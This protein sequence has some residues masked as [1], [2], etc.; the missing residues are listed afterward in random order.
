ME[1]DEEFF[2][3]REY[4]EDANGRKTIAVPQKSNSEVHFKNKKYTEFSHISIV[5]QIIL[6]F[7][8]SSWIIKFN[9]EGTHVAIAGNQGTII[10]YSIGSKEILQNPTYLNEHT[11][12]ITNLSWSNHQTL[13]SSSID[14][15]VKEWGLNGPS[16]STFTYH[17]KVI[18]CCYL[19]QDNNFFVAAFED[20]VIRNVYIPTG[21]IINSVQ[22]FENIYC[23]ALSPSGNTAAVGMDKGKVIPFRIRETDFKLIDRPI[24]KAKN[25]RGFKKKGKK[26]SGLYFVNDN[27]L[28]VT[29]LDSNIRLFS[30]EDYQ[31][32][33]KYKGAVLKTRDFCGTATYDKEYVICGSESGKFLIWRYQLPGEV[34]N[35]K[36]ESVKGG[37]AK[38]AEYVSVAP[39]SA[40][41][42]LNRSKGQSAYNYLIVTIDIG[43][44][45]KIYLC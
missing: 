36:Y 3:A 16:I 23:L 33:Q 8:S 32:K 45:L 6:P 13:L 15:T 42:I 21:Q 41:E 17:C 18:S 5:S 20:F 34:K 24:L 2:D 11:Y 38:T 14:H 43:N 39:E 4:D 27:E 26:V 37:K 1:S 35:R 7:S 28:V 40:V 31:M 9:P 30:L 22:L 44:S 29:T 19:P 12:D 10:L 25:K